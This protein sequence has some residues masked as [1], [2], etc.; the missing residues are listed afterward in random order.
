MAV[1]ERGT[2]IMEIYPVFFYWTMIL[3][4]GRLGHSEP[5]DFMMNIIILPDWNPGSTML[6]VIFDS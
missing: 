6:N 2:T 1:L 4:K 3:G 5:K